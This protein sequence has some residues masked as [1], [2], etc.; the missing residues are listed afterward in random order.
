MNCLKRNILSLSTLFF[1]GVLLALNISCTS[2][3]TNPVTSVK[4][5]T[6]S[7][8]V[9]MAN[10]VMNRNPELIKMGLNPQGNSEP[11]WQYDIGMLAQA[12]DKLGSIDSKYSAYMKTYIDYFISNDGI[13]KN[14]TSCEFN[15]DK[16]NPG[17]NLIIL[18]ERTGEEKYKKAIS[19][20]VDQLTNQPR[21]P[22]GGFWH[23]Y[24][25]TYQMWLDGIYMASPFMA[26][27]GNLSGEIKWFDEPVRQIMLIE[28]HTRDPK[29][30][31]LYHGYD[32][33]RG[34]KWSNDSTGCSPEFWGRAMGWY[35]MAIVDVLDFLP[36]NHP[37]RDSLTAILNRTCEALLKVR[38]PETGL[39]FQVLDK[40]GKEG[41]YLES[42]AS[43]M[44]TY[45]FA[46]GAN[47]GYLDK[48][49]RKIAEDSFDSIL[50][51]FIETG[52]DG[53]ININNACFGAGL[54]GINYR[55]GSYDYYIKER[56]GPN[57]QKAIAPFILLCL[58]LNK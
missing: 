18:Y 46:K 21:N 56:K 57:D 7:W 53:N 40:G 24:I 47:K 51:E 9:R 3:Q 15:L 16:V 29:T 38:D 13:I 37:G 17:N 54:G 6:E 20:L 43:C 34:M 8:A 45:A 33:S 12:I 41:N 48:K 22:D 42:T 2:A 19:L 35:V 27:Y 39:W 14:Y 31:L 11:K 55:D 58:E 5:T 52:A 1:A 10:S 36:Q 4:A 49:F 32:A 50:A 26:R 44:F 25:Y 23:K 30:G 28:K